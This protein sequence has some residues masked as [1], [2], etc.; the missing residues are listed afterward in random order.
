MS[1][2]T[3]NEARA[4]D[5]WWSTNTRPRARDWPCL[6]PLKESSLRRRA[7]MDTADR[8]EKRVRCRSIPACQ[9]DSE[10]PHARRIVTGWPRRR[11][12]LGEP[13]AARRVKPDPARPERAGH[14][15]KYPATV[16][17]EM[18]PADSATRTRLE[19][20]RYPHGPKPRNA[21]SVRASGV[22]A[23]T[24]RAMM[25]IALMLILTIRTSY[26]PLVKSRLF[27]SKWKIR[28]NTP[29]R[30]PSGG[31]ESYQAAGKDRSTVSM[32]SVIVSS[33][34]PEPLADFCRG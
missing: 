30:A 13:R 31:P 18:V 9:M 14:A 22:R 16:G 28:A 15:L 21:G 33:Q 2:R 19:K 12:R 17:R 24:A 29:R 8:V 11:R 4:N 26:S 34:H 5:P 1:G 32:A 3:R 23:R 27:G 6:I 20:D 25:E 10:L 7:R